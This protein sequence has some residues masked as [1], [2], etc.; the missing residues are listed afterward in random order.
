MSRTR[1][2]AG[3]GS[4][5][6][7]GVVPAHAQS[8]QQEIAPLFAD[9]L[10]AANARNTDAFLARYV[11]DSTLVFVFDGVVTTGFTAVRAGQLQAWKNGT[12]N[13]VYTERAP[14][15]YLELSPSI[16]AVTRQ[17]ASHRSDSTGRSVTGNFAV[18]EIWQKR[19]DGWRV[20]MAHESTTR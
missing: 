8:P 10:A 2:L 18:T 6:F 1:W 11:H 20:V 4:I 7:I 15:Q 13:V 5:L 19:A 9:M 14:A 17:L 16:V 12:S 3:F